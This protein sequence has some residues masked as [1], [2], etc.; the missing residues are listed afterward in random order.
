M[1]SGLS[2][3]VNWF[4]LMAIRVLSERYAAAITSMTAFFS[5]VY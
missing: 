4:A 2:D 1:S 3:T 5:P